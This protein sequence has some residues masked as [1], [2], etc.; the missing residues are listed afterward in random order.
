MALSI[1]AAE[2]ALEKFEDRKELMNI[3]KKRAVYMKDALTELGFKVVEP[4][5]AFYIFADYSKISKL[6]SFDFAMDMLKRVQTAVVPGISFGT[7]KCF[8]ISLTV[9]ISKLKEAVERI[10]EYVEKYKN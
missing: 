3:Y 6:N 8:R 5:G 7:E 4:K 9:D 10:E 1:A 2:I